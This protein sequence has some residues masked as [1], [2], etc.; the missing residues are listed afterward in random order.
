MAYTVHLNSCLPLQKSHGESEAFGAKQSMA[1][2]V[3][4][5]LG[6]SANKGRQAEEHNKSSREADKH[7]DESILLVEK[8]MAT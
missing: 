2:T 7:D 5:V 6:S 4:W 3:H 1:Y 8:L